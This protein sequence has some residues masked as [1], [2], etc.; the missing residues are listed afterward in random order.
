MQSELKSHKALTINLYCHDATWLRIFLRK[1]A[2]Y[3]NVIFSQA[4]GKKARVRAQ[5]TK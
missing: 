5:N 3:T 1:K 4:V 2:L